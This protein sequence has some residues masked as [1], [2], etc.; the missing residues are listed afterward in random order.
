MNDTTSTLIARLME[1]IF[2]IGMAGCVVVIP[3]VAYKLFAV[4]FEKDSDEEK[5]PSARV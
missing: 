2:V 4:L 1:T 3:L 5:L